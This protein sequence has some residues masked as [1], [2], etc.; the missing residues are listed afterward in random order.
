MVVFN[1]SAVYHEVK[2]TRPPTNVKTKD[3]PVIKDL[4]VSLEELYSG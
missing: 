1:I 2:C 4:K 3:K